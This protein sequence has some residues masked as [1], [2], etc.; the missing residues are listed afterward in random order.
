MLS[1]ETNIRPPFTTADARAILQQHYGIAPTAIKPL[2]SELDRNY[3]IQ[4]A[5]G[6]QV[7]LKIAH[8]SVSD[9][10][11]DLQNKTLKHLR[12]TMTVF[13]QLLPARTGADT[14]TVSAANGDSYRARLLRYIEGVPLSEFRPHSDALLADI[15]RQLGK[16][17][18]T[19]QSFHHNEKRLSYRWNIGNLKDV[20]QYAADLPSDKKSLLRS[21]PALYEK[22]RSSPPCRRCATAIPTTIPTTAIS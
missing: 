16:L 20:A 14:I 5:D 3:H 6:E 9:S 2:P 15:G 12:A 22:P 17:S 11:L 13:P 8:S 10:I 19:M 18:A 7:V 1:M 4:T 21:L